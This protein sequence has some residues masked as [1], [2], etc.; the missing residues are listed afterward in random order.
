MV[1]LLV[2]D[3]HNPR[4]VLFQV[5]SMRRIAEDLPNARVEGRV[6][7]V[8]GALLRLETELTVAHPKSVAP[9]TLTGIRTA[10]SEVSTGLSVAYLI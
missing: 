7:D 5:T 4:S 6:S 10:L 2:L 1:D 9:E 8:L 3:A